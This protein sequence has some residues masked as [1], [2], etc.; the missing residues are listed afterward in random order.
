MLKIYKLSEL[1]YNH[2]ESRD[3]LQNPRA[4][5]DILQVVGA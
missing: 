5:Y 1:I 3:K 2:F 4:L